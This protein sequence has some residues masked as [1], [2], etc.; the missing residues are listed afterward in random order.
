M[1]FAS[2]YNCVW[3]TIKQACKELEIDV[4]RA[5]EIQEIGPIINQIFKSIE[6]ADLL[7]AEI[8][9][10]NPNVYYEVGVSH[11][12][13]K[14]TVLLARK[15][16][17]DKKLLPFDIM[18]NRVVVY[19]IKNTENLRHKLIQQLSFLKNA[20]KDN[21]SALKI[22][23]FFKG[24]NF[25]SEVFRNPIDG[26]LSHIAKTFDLTDPKLVEKKML[27]DGFLVTFKDAFG[28]T[29]KVLVDINGIIKV[30]KRLT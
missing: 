17:V 5:D 19:D 2:D 24:L 29:I 30:M 16:V 20:I 1:P 26:V 10:K 25:E 22:D 4:V 15:E 21:V 13:G 27:P 12:L 3:Q 11:S 9:E 8:S 6:N 7:I 18:H 28:E 23:N 14:P